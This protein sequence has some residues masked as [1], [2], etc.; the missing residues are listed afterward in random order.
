MICSFYLAVVIER[1]IVDNLTNTSLYQCFKTTKAWT[2]RNV[3]GGMI[4]GSTLA[5][6]EQN[7][8]LLSMYTKA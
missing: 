3:E 5:S 1:L 7:G 6:S 4:G 2:K 8:I